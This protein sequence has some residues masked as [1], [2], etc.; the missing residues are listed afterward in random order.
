MTEWQFIETAPKDGTEVLCFI[1][2]H[3]SGSFIVGCDY[4]LLSFIQDVGWVNRAL[5][6]EHPTHWMPNLKPPIMEKTDD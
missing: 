4:R 2:E 5:Y 3:K 6:K 1:P